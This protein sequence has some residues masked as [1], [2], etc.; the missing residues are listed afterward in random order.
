[1]HSSLCCPGHI[2]SSALL[3]TENIFCLFQALVPPNEQR[4]NEDSKGGCVSKQV[5]QITNPQIS[6]PK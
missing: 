3:K 2:F 6:G 4:N 1:M 5:L